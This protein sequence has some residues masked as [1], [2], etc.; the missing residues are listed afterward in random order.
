MK[1]WLAHLDR[2]M[3][4]MGAQTLAN[5]GSISHKEAKSKAEAGF[6]RYRA[7]LDSETSAV[8]RAFLE[9]VKQVQRQVDGG[10]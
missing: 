1:D 7:Q 10:A 8:E 4:A 2:L 6:D 5:A 3:G 9:T